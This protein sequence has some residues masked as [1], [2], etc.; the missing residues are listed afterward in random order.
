MAIRTA[1]NQSGNNQ[2][3]YT[4]SFGGTSAAAPILSGVVALMLEANPLLGWRDV[5]EI[6]A[7][8]AQH[9]GTAIGSGQSGNEQ[10][11]WAFNGADNWNGGG[12]HFSNDYGTGVVD[13]LAAVRLAETWQIQSISANEVSA[14]GSFSGSIAI[15]DNNPTGV[16][17]SISVASNIDVESIELI[18]QGNHTYMGDLAI[19]ITS[20]DG[21][22]SNL[23]NLTGG[24]TDLQSAGWTL[25]SH[26]FRGELSSGNWIVNISD[27]AADDLG[28]I[29][30]LTLNVWG[31]AD[32]TN[33]VYVYT[34]EFSDYDGV[35]GHVTTI[36]DASGTDTINAA[37][38]TSGS[39]IDLGS[40]IATIDGVANHI[41]QRHRECF[42]WRRQMTL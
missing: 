1:T 22:V 37:A 35:S 38:V 3:D 8:S 11:D 39:T 7:Y 9:T 5:Q 36:A 31:A 21:T 30:N 18:L 32:I 24:A 26:A 12:L 16:S 34:D 14:S 27:N 20:P 4:S 13:A 40:G 41:Q 17:F 10:Y 25:T 28:T 42:W 33:D 23:L 2:S 19:T 29:T 15:P 6:L